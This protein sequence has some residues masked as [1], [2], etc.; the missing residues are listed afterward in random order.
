[1]QR[2]ML[3]RIFY[4]NP[5]M[6]LLDEPLTGLDNIVAA[7]L[8]HIIKDH[9]EKCPTIMVTHNINHVSFADT[10]LTVFLTNNRMSITVESVKNQCCVINQSSEVFS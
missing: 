1:M 4:M 9:S 7:E 10:I 2:L 8:L 5:S 6:F 3:A